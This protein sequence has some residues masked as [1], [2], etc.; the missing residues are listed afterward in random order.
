MKYRTTYQ[1]HAIIECTYVLDV[2]DDVVAEG[3]QAI[4]DYCIDHELY[5]P[6]V[7]SEIIDWNDTVGGSYEVEEA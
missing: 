1:Q 5:A 4:K 7:S 2:P 3:E 6:E